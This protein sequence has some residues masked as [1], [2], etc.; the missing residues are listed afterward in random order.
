MLNQGPLGAVVPV[1]IDACVRGAVCIGLVL[2]ERVFAVERAGTYVAPVWHGVEGA[3]V[4]WRGVEGAGVFSVLLRKIKSINPYA[5][6]SAAANALSTN[7]ALCAST[8]SGSYMENGGGMTHPLSYVNRRGFVSE[9]RPIIIRSIRSGKDGC[10]RKDR[11]GGGIKP[12]FHPVT[13]G[14]IWERKKAQGNG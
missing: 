5:S 3:G 1:A 11:V 8:I 2:E 14:G 13:A 6:A 12:C 9:C 10:A 4:A 7:I